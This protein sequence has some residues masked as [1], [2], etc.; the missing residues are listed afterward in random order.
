[1]LG[2]LGMGS[3]GG[4]IVEL[5]AA[6]AGLRNS[7]RYS[8]V[9]VQGSHAKKIAEAQRNCARPRGGRAWRARR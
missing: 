5:D 1:V 2:T 9:K 4:A 8:S 3:A 6:R 7:G